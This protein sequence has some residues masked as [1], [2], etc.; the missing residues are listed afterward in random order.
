MPAN[1]EAL[2]GHPWR[3]PSQALA[4]ILVL[5]IVSVA[6]VMSV[7][8]YSFF[9]SVSNQI[10]ETV[11]NDLRR[12][13]RIEGFHVAELLQNEINNVV[14]NVITSSQAPAI[15]RGEIE[16]GADIINRRQQST[17]DLTDRYLW[18][19]NEGKTVWSSAFVNRLEYELYNG[20]DVSDRPYFTTPASTGQPYFSTVQQS[21]VD[22][23][24]RMFIS[25]PIYEVG[26]PA[27]PGAFKGVIVGSIKADTLSMLVQSQLSP[28]IE[29]SVGIV[30]P[31][32]VIIYMAD[33][34]LV[35]ENVFGEKA[36]SAVAGAF[37]S[38]EE[39]LKFNDFLKRSI[40][41][42]TD[43][44]DFTVNGIQNTVTSWPIMAKTSLQNRSDGGTDYHFLTLYLTAPHNVAGVV[45]PLVE[46]QTIFSTAALVTIGAAT[47]VISYI[48]LSWNRRLERTVREKT[49]SVEQ[50]NVSLSESNQELAVKT[51]ELEEANEQLKVHDRM[52]TEFI[53]IAAH[54]LRTPVQPLLGAAEML[55]DELSQTKN[56]VKIT[57]PEVE[58]IIRNAKR[59]ARLTNDILEVSRIESNSLRLNKE[60]V[61]LI[62]KIR[63][64]IADT[65]AFIEDKHKL[66]IV[67]DHAAD[68]PI[69]VD[70]DKNRLFEV[71]SNIIR[72]AIKFTK[73]G[74]ITITAGK[75]DENAFVSIQDTGKG[76]DPAMIPKL[77]TRFASKS[78]SGTG[79]GLFI[80][81]SI[82]EAHGGT[83]RGENNPHGRGATFTF[84]IPLATSK[85]KE[86]EPQR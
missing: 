66:Q 67:F 45:G 83:I 9:V 32:G 61:N 22:K 80:A 27:G 55:E 15:V 74:T 10:D 30:D 34:D 12:Q 3:Y 62:E 5:V 78:D 41:G 76:I 31:K 79:L 86:P 58:M 56:N 39:S 43:A 28:E 1:Q 35:G 29:S 44:K 53:N 8:S 17:N 52:Q 72:N 16:Q 37:S 25:Y 63:N 65:C 40:E 18:I 84:N 49:A 54:E 26:S 48:I 4:L 2:A 68:E 7:A 64:V 75:K 81:K 69:F 23:S 24:Q 36:Q 11:R 77:F 73:E 33:P 59:L 20:F 6:V 57:I 42:T 21:P 85:E 82:V 13:T 70:A 60:R 50:A 51:R 47:A 19:D 38:E 46:Q 14:I 71:L